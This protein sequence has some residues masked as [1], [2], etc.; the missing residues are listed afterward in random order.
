MQFPVKNTYYIAGLCAILA[1]V[2][3]AL[4]LP[5]NKL[6]FSSSGP[7][8]TFSFCCFGAALGLGICAFFG[9]NTPFLD[10]TRHLRKTDII[11]LACILLCFTVLNLL[12]YNGL[13]M[14]SASDA[15]VLQSFTTVSTAL[16]AF[17]IFR[18]K[19]P[20]RLWIGI[21]FIT[22]G[23]FALSVSGEQGSFSFSLGSILIIA[24]CITQSFNYNFM[25]K[26][27]ER[28]PCEVNIIKFIASGAVVFTIALATGEQIPELSSILICVVIGFVSFALPPVFIMYAQRE[29][30]AAK[31][32]AIT[33]LSPLIGSVFAFLLFW[34][35]PE[36]TFLGALVLI[37]PGLYFALTRNKDDT[38]KKD[39]EEK[40]EPVLF[41]TLGDAARTENR[42]YFSA[43]GF[44]LMALMYILV[45]FASLGTD[46]ADA[47]LISFQ[48]E[49]VEITAGIGVLLLLTGV[50]LLI[51]GK[52]VLHAVTFL[53]FGALQILFATA[54]SSEAI[55][56]TIAGFSI[57]LAIIFLTSKE[58]NKHVFAVINLFYGIVNV[59]SHHYI[60][61]PLYYV[62]MVLM[63]LLA[64]GL[65][66]LA[67][68]CAAQKH[69]LPLTNYLT[70]DSSLKF[71]KCG[72]VLGY[73]F[74]AMYIS[75]WLAY[76]LGKLGVD[77][78]SFDAVISVE[79][80]CV[81]MLVFIGLLLLFIGRLRFTP[82]M[83]IAIG[84]ALWLDLYASGTMKY[85]VAFLLFLLGVFCVQRWYSR[86]LTSILL[87]NFGF[88]IMLDV[89]YSGG[90]TELSVV[91][92]LINT[93]CVV[94]SLYLSV[95]VF[96]EKPKLPLF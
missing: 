78:M 70:S 95:A 73:L 59:L 31:T 33:G 60:E 87:I 54:G 14:T 52:R 2:T 25:N 39:V 18:E 21:I 83:F 82:V 58:K 63:I 84:L 81:F 6:M 1:A 27:S 26:L 92:L 44:I 64:L 23:S 13:K 24:A 65:I 32:A 35:L 88:S 68:A 5:L 19:I 20:K 12:L 40:T 7:L 29:F 28:N 22:L 66:Y 47:T 48:V 51:F 42:N 90:I 93:V 94:L 34:E 43:L 16:V 79:Q 72:P 61:G 4:E 10:K 85:A 75:L 17:F 57:L 77:V 45:L 36:I 55:S 8:M 80:V 49:M 71:Q 86:L 37:I 74:L 50:I 62:S 96:S 41:P 15:S 89:L 76:D 67:L 46:A 69:T 30:K 9:R 56:G 91:I 53:F 11:H 38:G 3:A